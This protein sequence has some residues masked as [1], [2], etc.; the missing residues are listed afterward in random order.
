MPVENERKY[1][2]DISD[3]L[4]TFLGKHVTKQVISQAYLGVTEDCSV[5]VREVN[6]KIRSLTCKK[7]VNGETIEISTKVS[8]EDY[9]KLYGVSTQKL[10]KHRYIFGRWEVDFLKRE[11]GSTYFCLAE[12][13][14]LPGETE[15]EEMPIELKELLVWE[16]PKDHRTVQNS[17]LWH[18]PSAENL[19]TTAKSIKEGPQEFRRI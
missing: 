2:L 11:D 1:V 14:L 5:R 7:K 10:L 18:I 13:E 17:Y 6:G 19:L 4:E 9:N 16:A 12:Y 15:V 3:D 8:A